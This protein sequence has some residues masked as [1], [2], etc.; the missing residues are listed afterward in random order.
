VSNAVA[1]SDRKTRA[2]AFRGRSAL[3]I[4]RQS[5][6]FHTFDPKLIA[7]TLKNYP[8]HKC[9]VFVNYVKPEV[10]PFFL[11]SLKY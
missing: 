4:G 3:D 1:S 10:W 8:F 6:L 5:T 2:H 7:R 9:A 11:V